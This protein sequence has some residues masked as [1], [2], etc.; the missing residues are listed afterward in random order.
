MP[1]ECPEPAITMLMPNAA[2]ARR[3]AIRQQICVRLSPVRHRIRVRPMPSATHCPSTTPEPRFRTSSFDGRRIA[4]GP[5]YPEHDATCRER[6]DSLPKSRTARRTNRP[7]GS[8]RPG[9][10][11]LSSRAARASRGRVDPPPI[12]TAIAGKPH[13]IVIPTLRWNA[14]V[15]IHAH[16]GPRERERNGEAALRIRS[17]RSS[18]IA[19]ARGSPGKTCRTR[20][21]RTSC[22]TRSADPS[23]A[24]TRRRAATSSNLVDDRDARDLT[25]RGHEARARRLERVEL[26]GGQPTRPTSASVARNGGP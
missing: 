24:R 21:A 19:T 8:R 22:R 20:S 7:G 12:A 11:A 23:S 15:A 25:Y 4:H 17:R 6:L 16:A 1:A 18:S 10:V 5:R 3:T 14:S 13:Q 26:I 2:G 9:K